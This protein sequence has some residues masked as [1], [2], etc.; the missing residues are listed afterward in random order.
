[1]K[2]V[3]SRIEQLE[4]IAKLKE[5]KNNFKDIYPLT[6]LEFTKLEKQ[7]AD[8]GLLTEIWHEVIDGYEQEHLDEL[9]ACL[10]EN[11]IPPW[12]RLMFDLSRH[13]KHLNTF[14]KHQAYDRQLGLEP[15]K[16]RERLIKDLKAEID[17][18]RKQEQALIKRAL[19]IYKR[20]KSEVGI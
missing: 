18:T 8:R 1:M 14:E 10:K 4:K 3:I 20:R 17:D 6:P 5:P 11:M 7:G 13:K 19:E 15:D 16:T 9:D 12:R 2:A